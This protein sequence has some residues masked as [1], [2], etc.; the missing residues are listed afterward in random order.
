MH[1][2]NID[3]AGQGVVACLLGV[4]P[5]GGFCRT[6]AIQD[7]TPV[8]VQYRLLIALGIGSVFAAGTGV[9]VGSK[10][11]AFQTRQPPLA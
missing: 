3:V 2:K 1:F 10:Q 5:G 11:A 4:G 7:G 8:G 6:I 9:N